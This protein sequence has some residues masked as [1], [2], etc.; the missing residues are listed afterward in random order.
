MDQ[1]SEPRPPSRRSVGGELIIPIAAVAFTLY[2]FT[3]IIDSPW[4]AQV[5]ALF[6]GS[7]L[8]GLV[9]IL[10]IKL[11]RELV[12]G[13]ADLRLGGLIEP[14]SVAPKR[15]IVL[16]LAIG[17]VAVIEWLGFTLTTFAFLAAAMLVLNGG[18]RPAFVLGLA[19][20]LSLGGYLLFMVA[21]QTRFPRGP[22]EWLMGA[23]F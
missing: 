6:V 3:S 12:A 19:A 7:I 23:V 20:G 8:L 18:R 10:L 16:L 22:F 9:V 13:A 21:F 1:Q 15:L 11:G 17:Y 5:N 14:V 2:Y 4:E